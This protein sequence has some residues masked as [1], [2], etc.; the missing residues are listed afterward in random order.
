MVLGKSI[1][2]SQAVLI[3]SD[4]GSLELSLGEP[5]VWS[6]MP[7]V[8]DGSAILCFENGTVFFFLLGWGENCFLA[9]DKSKAFI[10]LQNRQVL[11][12]GVGVESIGIAKVGGG[13]L[14]ILGTT[15]RG[16]ANPHPWWWIPRQ[17][18]IRKSIQ[19]YA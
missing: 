4:G 1:A 8:K 12:S 9:T 11:S 2:F 7:P 15:P 14:T 13:G 16:G 3:S 6:I 17:T 10:L 5:E 19:K 18:S